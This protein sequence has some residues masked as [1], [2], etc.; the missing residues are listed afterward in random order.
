[1]RACLCVVLVLHLTC[2]QATLV[3]IFCPQST[4]ADLAVYMTL[5]ELPS[6]PAPDRRNLLRAVQLSENVQGCL[7]LTGLPATDSMLADF[8]TAMRD[9]KAT[10]VV[11]LVEPDELRALAPAYNDTLRSD[12]LGVSVTQFAI[13]DLGVPDDV[14]AFL[15]RAKNIAQALQN[16][17]RITVHCR[18]GIGRTGMMAQ[19]VLVSLG[20]PLQDAAQRVADAGSHCE[21]IEQ[22]AFLQQMFQDAQ[23]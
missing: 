14:P 7:W 11:V 2:I 3:Q 22:R 6:S 19:A 12:A 13:R 10:Q 16:G 4:A 1:M 15:A 21:T 5:N 23:D 20:L 18:A 17:A 8:M 9:A